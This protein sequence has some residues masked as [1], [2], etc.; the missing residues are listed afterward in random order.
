MIRV[1]VRDFPTLPLGERAADPELVGN[2]RIALIVRRVP[3]VDPDLHG[4]TSVENF[5]FAA[6]LELEQLASCLPGEYAH[7][8]PKCVIAWRVDHRRGELTTDSRRTS[9]L[10][11][12]FAS[13]FGH[14]TPAHV[15]RRFA[16]CGVRDGDEWAAPECGSERVE[17][18][19]SAEGV[20]GAAIAS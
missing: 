13:S 15:Q 12:A 6:Q 3:R 8:R 5:R 17:I 4:F 7:K 16:I 9:S 1:F 18:G 19:S 2:R 10:F 11:A 14:D 20:F